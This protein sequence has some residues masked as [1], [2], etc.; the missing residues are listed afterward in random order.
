[1]KLHVLVTTHNRINELQRAVNSLDK[2]IENVELHLI[3]ANSGEEITLMP[4]QNIKTVEIIS[5][6]TNSYWADSMYQAAKR[7]PRLREGD[8]VLWLNEDVTL[9]DGAIEKLIALSN[10]GAPVV[11][12]QTYDQKG[13]LTYGGFRSKNQ[14]FRLH[15][16]RVEAARMPEEVDTFNGNIVLVNPS[17]T[18]KLGIFLPGYKHALADIAYG[19]ELHKRGLKAVLAPGASGYCELNNSVNICFDTTLSRW[20]RVRSVFKANGLPPGPQFKY[21]L[22]YGGFAGLGYFLATYIRFVGKLLVFRDLGA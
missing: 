6:A 21:S 10:E 8:K 17:R 13:A 2:S 19:L 14:F 9:I 4:T 11:V 1:M 7:I 15:F 12:G 18:G 5:V 20:L 16:A 22:N 3:I